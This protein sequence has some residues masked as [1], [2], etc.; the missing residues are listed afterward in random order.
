M[1]APLEETHRYGQKLSGRTNS[2]TDPNVLPRLHK[3]LGTIRQKK[4]RFRGVFHQAT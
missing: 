1:A 2:G 3:G 4:P